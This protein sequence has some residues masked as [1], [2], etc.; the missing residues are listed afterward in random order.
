M[1]TRSDRLLATMLG[2]IV[3]LI[4][5]PSACIAQPTSGVGFQPITIADPVGG[6]DM[7]GLVFY[8]SDEA[9]RVTRRGPYELHASPGTAIAKG[10]KPLVVI[11]HGH[12]GSSLGHHDMAVHLAEHGF[13]VATVEHPKDNFHDTSGMGAVEVLV[14]RPVQIKSTISALLA[15]SRW[16][17]DAE[18]IGVAGFSA[19]GYTALMSVGAVPQFARFTGYCAKEPQ[20]IEVCGPIIHSKPEDNIDARLAARQADMDT[21]G[22]PADP[23]VKATFVMAPLSLLFD[24]KGLSKIRVPVF[25]YYAEADT[26][27]LPQYNTLHISPFIETLSGIKM[28]PKAGHY[29][30]LSPCS[31]ALK[32]EAPLICNDPAGVDRVAEHRRLNADALAFFSKALRISKA[33]IAGRPDESL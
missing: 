21:W 24:K 28:I 29:V 18:R 13:I 15:D 16:N 3:S 19:G 6:G 17:I 11:S 30:F 20:D 33:R 7:P 2:L 9:S 1:N 5:W 27:L 22:K 26:V 12:G 14:G 4:A 25:L 8:P 10:A 32:E 23:R 31:T